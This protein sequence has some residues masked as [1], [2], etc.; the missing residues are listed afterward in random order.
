MRERNYKILSMKK[1]I[2]NYNKRN[3]NKKKTIRY[4]NTRNINISRDD[5]FKN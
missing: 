2:L 3:F 4:H 5:Y 1:T